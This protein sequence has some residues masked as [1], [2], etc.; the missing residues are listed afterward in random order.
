M[1][2]QSEIT[3]LKNAVA[4]AYVAA[5]GKGAIIPSSKVSDNLASCI[6]SIKYITVRTGSGEP[7]ASLGEDGDI[8]IQL[9]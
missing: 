5:Q 8:Y 7:S 9:D 6:S 4:A 2:V 1:S 3:R